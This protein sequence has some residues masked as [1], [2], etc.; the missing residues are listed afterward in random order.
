LS[1]LD[2]PSQAIIQCVYIL[3]F[4]DFFPCWE[5]FA[6]GSTTKMDPPAVGFRPAP[7]PVNEELEQLYQRGLAKS[8][9]KHFAQEC[10]KVQAELT[11]ADVALRELEARTN[12]FAPSSNEFTQ[13]DMMCTKV[14]EWKKECKKKEQETVLLYAKYCEKFGSEIKLAKPEDLMTPNKRDPPITSASTSPLVNAD[15]DALTKAFEDAAG[16]IPSFIRPKGFTLPSSYNNQELEEI[17]E[18]SSLPDPGFPCKSFDAVTP[19]TDVTERMDSDF[20]DS[21]IVSGLT[22]LNS[23]QTRMV[24]ED[25]ESK[26]LDF[27]KSET[28][29]I[30]KLMEEE[31]A[32]SKAPQSVAFSHTTSAVE[33][34][35]EHEEMARKMQAVLDDFKKAEAETVKA[36]KVTMGRRIDAGNESDEWYEHWDETLERHY[37]VESKTNKSQWEKPPTAAELNSYSSTSLGDSAETSSSSTMAVAPKVLDYDFQPDIRDDRRRNRL[38]VYKAKQSRKRKRQMVVLVVFSGLLVAAFLYYRHVNPGQ[39]D[40][41]LETMSTTVTSTMSGEAP[42][43][44]KPEATPAKEPKTRMSKE[45]V[46]EPKKIGEL[47]TKETATEPTAINE[48]QVEAAYKSTNKTPQMVGSKTPSPR[49]E[50][51]EASADSGLSGD[52]ALL[53]ASMML[54]SSKAP[55]VE[56]ETPGSGLVVAAPAPHW[57]VD[58]LFGHHHYKR[59]TAMCRDPS[60]YCGTF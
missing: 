37:Y 22:T 43:S 8:L 55:V 20:D 1:I 51:M 12:E 56:H 23:H 35:D 10:K 52:L 16:G 33:S 34:V 47:M 42:L 49:R 26:V 31:D 58:V 14:F 54:K 53:L 11:S 36:M 9:H 7:V 48:I 24:L 38:G 59:V 2:D 19:F 32:A 3:F 28:E 27:I 18:E 15:I 30:R 6:G 60:R 13:L 21:S 25:V 41:V 45:K 29:N 17:L 57:I 44:A 5:T 4:L 46:F 50:E 39:V 40:S